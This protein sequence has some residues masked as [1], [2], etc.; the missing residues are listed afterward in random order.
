MMNTQYV[1]KLA[2]EHT[3]ASFGLDKMAAAF[4]WA[5]DAQRVALANQALQAMKARRAAATTGHVIQNAIPGAAANMANKTLAIDAD[6]MRRHI[7]SLGKAV[8]MALRVGV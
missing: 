2:F 8:P 3:L 1:E 4:K 7:Q 5:V 6:A